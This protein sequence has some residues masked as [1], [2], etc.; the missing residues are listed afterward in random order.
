MARRS[1]FAEIQHQAR[2]A[3]REAERQQRAAARE[4]Q[5]ALR[6]AEQARKVDERARSQAARAA[7]AEQKRLEKEAR[8]AHLAAMEAEVQLKN[9]ELAQVYEEIDGLLAATLEVDD[10]VDLTTLRRTVEHPPFD[11]PDLEVATPAPRSP[12]APPEPQL[13]LPEP[14]QV[15][16][17]RKRKHARA[18]AAARDP[19]TGNPT[20][21]PFVAVAAER[22]TFLAIDLSGV[23]P[24]ATIEYLG[25]S[26][27]KN[28]FGLVATDISGVRRS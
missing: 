27:S 26:I 10:F 24:Q 21:I 2:M 22:E 15:L 19:A 5:Q 23:V 12:D 7:A 13:V 11:R 3:L 17:G 16:F 28:P 6:R 20:Y 14:P 4:H 1:F 18:V 9:S 25:G 8:A